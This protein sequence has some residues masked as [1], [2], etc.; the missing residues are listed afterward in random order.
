ML[1]VVGLIY[2]MLPK[3]EQT[4]LTI[5][6]K[7]TVVDTPTPTNSKKIIYPTDEFLSRIIKKPFGI[8][9]TPKNSPVQPEKFS[10]YHTGVDVE[11]EDVESEVPVYSVCDGEI[12]TAGH[13]NGYGGVIGMKCDQDFVIYGHLNPNSFTS[14]KN[15]KLG[16]KIGQLGKGYSMETDGERKHLHFGIHKNTL[17]LRGYVK[18][19]TELEGWYDQKMIMK[20]LGVE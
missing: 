16:D 8:Y 5:N 6:T 14:K 10:G 15:V 13:V 7:P 11:Y 19:E 1:L 9:I 12:I 17:D 18:T 20:F 4:T 2:T 3:R